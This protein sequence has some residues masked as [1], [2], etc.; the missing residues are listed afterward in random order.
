MQKDIS[1]FRFWLLLACND[2]TGKQKIA[3][4]CAINESLIPANDRAVIEVEARNWRAKSADRA[5]ELALAGLGAL[6]TS[7][8]AAS[9]VPAKIAGGEVLVPEYALALAESERKAKGGDAVAQLFFGLAYQNGE[10]GSVDHGR[11]AFWFPKSAEQGNDMAQLFLG[12]KYANGEG[13]PQDQQKASHWYL[14]A[15]EQGLPIAQYEVG[16]RYTNGNGVAK[17]DYQALGWFRKA[18]EQGDA[19]A[20]TQVGLSYF[21]GRGVTQDYQQAISWTRRSADQNNAN[22]QLSLGEAYATGKGVPK[23]D[24]QAVFW[25]KKAATQGNAYAQYRL[26][27]F[28]GAGAGVAKDIQQAYFWWLL[29][30]ARGYAEAARI[31]D[32][33]EKFLTAEQRSAAQA[34]ARDWQPATT[35]QSNAPFGKGSDSESSFK[36]AQ[37]KPTAS[38]PDSTGNGFRVARGAIV[39][40]HH[41]INGCGRLSVNGVVAQVRGSD[42][43]SDLALLS[44]IV[45]G[46]STNLRARRAAVGEAVAVAGYPLRG[47]LSGFNMTTGNLSSLSGI[48]G[49]TRLLQITAPVQPGNSGGPMLDSAGNL[50]GVVVSKLDAIKAAKIIGDIPQN[51]NFAINVNV[52]RS[53]LDAYSVEYETAISDKI[54]ATTSIAD[55]AMGFTVLVE[56]W[57]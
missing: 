46:S 4:K 28:Y 11:A 54:L 45:P 51:V 47:L 29:S 32:T 5:K 10:L 18:A 14:K 17:D 34:S 19:N 56:C 53:F 26:G 27:V 9:T 20:Q 50:M 3:E 55:K 22:G 12:Q 30:A 7:S 36:P 57:K 8:G 44:S 52:L 35:A 41:V 49:D 2:V 38:Q 25:I 24:Q 23:D 13:V 48:G 43:R 15:A 37:I 1:K 21:L 6:R 16:L 33:S 39:T 40:N 42:A 31:R